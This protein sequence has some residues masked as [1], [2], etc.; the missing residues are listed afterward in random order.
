MK[1]FLPAFL[2]S[3]LLVSESQAQFTRYLVKLKNKGGTPFTIANPIAYLSQ[4][5]ID[6]RTRY[7]IAIDSTDL[8][9]TPSYVTQIRNVP[10]VTIL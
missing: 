6:R 3:L 1:K 5:A 2:F 7:G 9:V 4:R 8:P 10:N